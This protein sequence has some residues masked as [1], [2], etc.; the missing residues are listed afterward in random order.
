MRIT[1]RVCGKDSTQIGAQ[2]IESGP[3]RDIGMCFSYRYFKQWIECLLGGGVV[4]NSAHL[5]QTDLF[6][7]AEEELF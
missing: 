6:H 3:L 2:K 1:L 4:T 5:L 7:Q